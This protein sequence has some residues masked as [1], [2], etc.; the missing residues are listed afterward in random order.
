MS[1]LEV[2]DETGAHLIPGGDRAWCQVQEPGA[3][4]ILECHGKPV[5]HDLL[6]PVGGF[7]AQLIE[8]EELRRVS[9]AIYRGGWSGLNLPGQATLCSSAMKARQP[10][11]AAGGLG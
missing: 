4:P 8:L 2:G 11:V 5:R 6:I 9:R 10:A 1:T 7:D 3:G